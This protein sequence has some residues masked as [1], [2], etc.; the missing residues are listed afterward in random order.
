MSMKFVT[1]SRLH[2][3][4]ITFLLI[5]AYH[6]FSQNG[7]T[8]RSNSREVALIDSL[9]KLGDNYQYFNPDSALFYY[10]KARQIAEQCDCP[11]LLAHIMNLKAIVLI[12]NGRL[13]DAYVLL[14]SALKI[15]RDT[16]A[17]YRIKNNLATIYSEL[18]F[19]RKSFEIHRQALEHY[20][21]TGDSV[22]IAAAY[23]NLAVL[24]SEANVKDST[25]LYAYKALDLDKKLKDSFGLAFDFYNLGVFYS[26]SRDYDSANV[27]LDS[28]LAYARLLGLEFWMSNIYEA[29]GELFDSLNLKDSAWIYYQK[30][31]EAA[32]KQQNYGDLVS[33]YLTLAEF[34][35]NHNNLACTKDYLDSASIYYARYREDFSADVKKNYLKI[36]YLYFKAVDRW[37]SALVYHEAF[38]RL[39]DSLDARRQLNQM[40]I[41]KLE[42][43]AQQTQ[44]KLALLKYKAEQ[45]KKLLTVFTVVMI[46]LAVL[47]A[48]MLF[49]MIRLRTIQ[50]Q[51]AEKNK[52]LEKLLKKDKIQ[53]SLFGIQQIALKYADSEDLK[54]FLHKVLEAVLR[55]DWIK[56]EN[57]GAIYLKNDRGE[58]ELIAHKNLNEK[59]DKCRIIK[60]GQCLC[61]KVFQTGQKI[62]TYHLTEEHLGS[63]SEEDHGH[64]I[65]PLGIGNEVLGVLNFYL[66]PGQKLTQDEEEFLNQFV[67]MLSLIL[68]RKISRQRL[69]KIAKKQDELNQRLFAQ[70]LLLEE[71]KRKVEQ[72]SE[73]IKQQA[74]QIKKTLDSLQDG[75]NYAS[76]MLESLLPSEKLMDELFKDYFLIFKPIDKIGGDFYFASR[77]EDKIYL[78]VGD[79]TGHGVPGAILAAQILGYL[80]EVI[81]Q[82]K[83]CEPKEILNSLR[84]KVKMSYNQASH[85]SIRKS[86]VDIGMCVFDLKTNTLGF[87]GANIPLYLIRNGELIKFKP[88]KSP[89]GLYIKEKPF[90]QHIISLQKGDLLYLQSDGFVDQL[91]EQMKKFARKR[92]ERMLLEISDLPMKDQKDIILRILEEWKGSNEQTDD[93]IIFGLRWV[94]G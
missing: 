79:A 68:E 20:K 58:L 14:D 89:V 42:L 69:E 77:L 65:A 8:N 21:R 90:E 30:S 6:S 88:T 80:H 10:E 41:L 39:G 5:P 53:I 12:D 13:K 17:A 16:N 56:I 74:Q 81:Q 9:I 1:D 76:Y 38:V 11:D 54:T 33:S 94:Y 3:F 44:K 51:L 29:L 45:R 92:Y 15:V 40:Q 50:K 57:K 24:Y 26:H 52:S 28:A 87:A 86:G 73:K 37:D 82:R 7:K 59:A 46:V 71:E 64:F 48:V 23:S 35:L 36:K 75:I 25:F 84:D 34:C 49:L 62:I 47:F 78:A 32:K 83:V 93:I 19:Y 31:L 55:L 60:P 22:A 66:K 27:F 70:S 4:L 63:D 43:D 91:S 2:L 67:V 18:G 72:A 61:G 85:E